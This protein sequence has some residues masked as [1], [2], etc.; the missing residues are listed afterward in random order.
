MKFNKLL[1]GLMGF[2]FLLT[3]CNTALTFEQAKKWIAENYPKDRTIVVSTVPVIS[4][5]FSG[6]NGNKANEKITQIFS[7]LRELAFDEGIEKYIVPAGEDLPAIGQRRIIPGPSQDDRPTQTMYPLIAEDFK[8]G[9]FSEDSKNDTYK[10]N[11]GCFSV[12][13]KNGIKCF[14]KDDKGDWNATSTCVR[15]FNK[16]GYCTDFGYKAN[17]YMDKNNT[18][19]F[20]FLIHFEYENDPID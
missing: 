10:I 4:W 11:N 1:V 5:D 18:V 15:V 14:D 2:P 8:E 16:V 19:K 3:S 20:K 12:T 9:T 17:K 13:Y 7:E 6:T